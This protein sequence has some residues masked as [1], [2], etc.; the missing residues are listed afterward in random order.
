M[1]LLDP[2]G[3]LEQP[4]QTL[5]CFAGLFMYGFSLLCFYRTRNNPGLPFGPALTMLFASA[6][7][8][9]PWF[10]GLQTDSY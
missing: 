10:I 3:R 1:G 4:P 7:M 6:L 8:I 2:S 5:N 9:L